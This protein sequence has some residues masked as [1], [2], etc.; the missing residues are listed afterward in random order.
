MQNVSTRRVDRITSDE[1]ERLRQG[2]DLMTSFRFAETRDGLV[3]TPAEY[4]IGDE[5]IA[6][7]AYA[8]TATLWRI[9]LGWSRRKEKNSFGFFLDM[10]KRGLG[11]GGNRAGRQ[12]QRG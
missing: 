5:V 1:E 6:S 10:E 11:A 7:A 8:P 3:R 2:Y 12:G 4:T 9:N